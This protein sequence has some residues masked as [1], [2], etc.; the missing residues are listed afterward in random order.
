M[1]LLSTKN[2]THYLYNTDCCINKWSMVQ[3][4][5]D[6]WSAIGARQETRTAIMARV[7]SKHARFSLS[8]ETKDNMQDTT[9]N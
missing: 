8:S 2:M 6:C 3:G 4:L 9:E 7:P 1:W 5:T